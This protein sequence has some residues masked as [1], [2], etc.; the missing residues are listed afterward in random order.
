M[1]LDQQGPQPSVLDTALS[2][3]SSS[4]RGSRRNGP[5]SPE[6]RRNANIVR[7][8][9]ACRRCVY[10][11]ETVLHPAPPELTFT[12]VDSVTGALLVKI[13][14]ERKE[15]SGRQDAHDNVL[16]I[17]EMCSSLVGAL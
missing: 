17:F 2:P 13:V 11:K 9:R 1:V 7:Q 14:R 10:M 15:G 12:D 3:T 16:T 4:E 6:A 8:L 5:L